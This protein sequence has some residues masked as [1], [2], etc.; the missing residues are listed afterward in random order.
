MD[1][2]RTTLVMFRAFS[3]FRKLWRGKSLL[4]LWS[5]LSHKTITAQTTR[6]EAGSAQ[7]SKAASAP[8]EFRVGE[9]R[10]MSI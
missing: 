2:S 10:Q 7:M 8:T 1:P 4:Y 6:L 5:S 9:G 3:T